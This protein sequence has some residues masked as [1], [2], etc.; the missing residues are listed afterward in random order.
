MKEKIAQLIEQAKSAIGQSN[1]LAL[2]NNVK[3]KYLGKSGELTQLL[4]GMKDLP[5]E[6]RP[7]VGKYV[8]EA[9]D[10]IGQW[11]S[12]KTEKLAQARLRAGME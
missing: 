8:N 2:I 12:E 1:T 6:E 4:R 9:R 10:Q 3:V 11:L 5:Q 7:L